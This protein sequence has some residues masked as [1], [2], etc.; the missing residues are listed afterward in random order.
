[1]KNISF[2]FIT[3]FCVFMIN[4]FT[5]I[6]YTTDPVAKTPAV[7]SITGAAVYGVFAGRTP[8]QEFLKEYNLSDNA[9]CAKR[10]MGVTLFEDSVS[11]KPTSYETWGMGKWTGKGNWH[12]LKGTP[13]DPEAIVFQLDLEPNTFLY[14]LKGDENVLFILDKKKNFL[15]G[16]AN[17]SYTLNREGNTIPWEQKLYLLNK[18]SSN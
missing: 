4:A 14:L 12:I 18:G 6:N 2:S 9:A 11:H 17:H 1:M 10:K 16:N 3:C 15:I 5:Q 8:C 7:S 13:T